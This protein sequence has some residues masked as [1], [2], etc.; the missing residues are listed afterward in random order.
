[1]TYRSL[2][3]IKSTNSSLY[4]ETVSWLNTLTKELDNEVGE[5]FVNFVEEILTLDSPF[6]TFVQ[7]DEDLNTVTGV[8][9]LVPDDQNVGLEFSLDGFWLG[10][11][12]IKREHRNKRYGTKLINYFD[13][14]ITGLQIKNLRLNLFT[15][16]PM[17]IKIY[18]KV[19]FLKTNIK[20]QREGEL[21]EIYYKVYN[22]T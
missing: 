19:G 11:V 4:L 15:N 14:Y 18:E 12:N 10:G 6:Q 17:A 21:N 7:Y 20:V 3:E 9:S 22:S 1:M 16:N 8:A 5:N 13:S 2:K